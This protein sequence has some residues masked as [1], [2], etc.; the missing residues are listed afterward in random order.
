MIA[1]TSLQEARW[2]QAIILHALRS[3]SEHMAAQ[4]QHLM[5]LSWCRER[6]YVPARKHSKRR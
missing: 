4:C 6:V 3:V 1:V 2:R 5:L